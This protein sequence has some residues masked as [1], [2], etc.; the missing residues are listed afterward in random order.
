MCADIC[1]RGHAQ[2]QRN[3]E[4]IRCKILQR[5][6][7][8]HV[9][10][11]SRPRCD[12]FSDTLF[13]AALHDRPGEEFDSCGIQ[14]TVTDANAKPLAGAKVTLNRLEGAKVAEDIQWETTSDKDGHYELAF[15]VAKGKTPI[16]REMFADLRGS[17]QG[18]PALTLPLKNGEKAPSTFAWKKVTAWPANCGCPWTLGT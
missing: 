11:A 10:A 2:P 12:W 13:R 4:M 7:L 1:T 9:G 8:T 17:A 15:R 18:A 6:V 16:I 5:M 3:R 14:G